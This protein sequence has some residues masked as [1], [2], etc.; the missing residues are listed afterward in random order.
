ML[1]PTAEQS[2]GERKENSKT[3]DGEQHTDGQ[4][5]EHT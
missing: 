2:N 3:R 1:E 4:H 5:H